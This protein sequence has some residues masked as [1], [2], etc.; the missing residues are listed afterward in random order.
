MA[1]WQLRRK[2]MPNAKF[3]SPLRPGPPPG[4]RKRSKIEVH[5]VLRECHDLAHYAL[6]LDVLRPDSS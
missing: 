5:R 6:N 4:M 3:T 1:R 2:S